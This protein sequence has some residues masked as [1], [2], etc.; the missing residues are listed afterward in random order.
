M[1]TLIILLVLSLSLNCIAQDNSQPKKIFLRVFNAEGKKIAKGKLLHITDSTITLQRNK[2]TTEIVFEDI[3][4]IKTKHSLGNN[5]LT[6]AVIGAGSIG[7]L[8]AATS[9]DSGFVQ[10]TGAEGFGVGSLIGAPLGEAAGAVTSIFKNVEV[11][12]I[13][14]NIENWKTFKSLFSD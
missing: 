4:I 14:G 12:E 11:F 7:I 10:Y 13:S 6:G 2:K 8:G 5:V 3:G 9:S 1:K